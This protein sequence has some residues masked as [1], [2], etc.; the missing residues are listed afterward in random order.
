MLN[1][2][3]VG[4]PSLL[5]DFAGGNVDNA[6]GALHILASIRLLLSST[7]ATFR[8]ATACHTRTVRFAMVYHLLGA[9]M[10]IVVVV[11]GYKGGR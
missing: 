8:F 10:V 6:R 3:V 5:N 4:T 2:Q 1:E 9:K 7:T 11:V